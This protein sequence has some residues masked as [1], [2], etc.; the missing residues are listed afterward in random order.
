MGTSNPKTMIQDYLRLSI[1]KDNLVNDL[2]IKEAELR[3]LRWL[4]SEAEY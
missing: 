1:E 3:K 2:K 4:Y